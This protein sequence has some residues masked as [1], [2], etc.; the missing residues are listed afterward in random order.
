MVSKST[1]QSHG[2]GGS[3]KQL[4]WRNHASIGRWHHRHVELGDGVRYLL[5]DEGDIDLIGEAV[6]GQEALEKISELN[7]DIAIIDV[8][9]PKL[10]GLEVIS[11]LKQN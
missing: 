3:R 5:Q 2:C 4:R 9:M 7:P 11:K 6:D 8:N 1:W 10:N